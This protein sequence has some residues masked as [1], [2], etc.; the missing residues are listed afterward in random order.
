M[1]TKKYW[2]VAAV[3]VCCAIFLSAIVL[4]ITAPEQVQVNTFG[5]STLHGFKAVAL[6]VEIQANKEDKAGLLTQND[7]RT[8]AELRL[9]MAGINVVPQCT[10]FDGGTLLV[11]VQVL[12]MDEDI[13]IYAF[14]VC[15]D[16]LQHI[17]LVRDRK[18]HAIA[19]TRLFFP[20]L[21]IAGL[22]KVNKT[23]KNAVD[24]QMDEFIND[25]LAANSKEPPAKKDTLEGGQ[26]NLTRKK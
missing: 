5:I 1:K 19:D 14:A 17:E 13:P 26:E 8:Q 11:N 3:I 10:K 7:L 15:V 16:H 6:T 20:S 9:R 22:D 21:A 24:K 12:R 25:Y 4:G 23:I 2:I 18:I